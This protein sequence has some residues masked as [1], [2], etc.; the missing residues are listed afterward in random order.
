MKFSLKN[1]YFKVLLSFFL[2]LIFCI[3]AYFE[4]DYNWVDAALVTVNI[5]AFIIV[6][7]IVSWVLL[8]IIGI[9]SR[10]ANRFLFFSILIFWWVSV[11]GDAVRLK[12]G[13]TTPTL[14]DCLTTGGDLPSGCREVFK[15]NYGT[16]YPSTDQMRNDYYNCK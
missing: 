13:V 8:S 3:Y 14:C 4:N 16:S 12:R 1:N 6:L 7:V 9:K 2:I 15:D 10:F 11:Y 5:T